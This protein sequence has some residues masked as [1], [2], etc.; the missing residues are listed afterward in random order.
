MFGLSILEAARD[1][2]TMDS[3]FFIVEFFDTLIIV[4]AIFFTATVAIEARE[5]RKSTHGLRDE[6]TRTKAKS[7]EWQ[8]AAETY[9]EGIG[10]AICEQF[11]AWGLS[12][13]ESEVAMLILKGLS[14]K[15]IADVRGIGEATVRQQAQAVY[16]KSG[17]RGRNELSAYFLE[18]ITL[19]LGDISTFKR[20]GVS[21]MR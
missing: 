2:D 6:L 7:A 14:H 16:S 4:A 10:K 18:D 5:L 1:G 21:Y 8:H 17:L 12:K 13:G 11:G 20:N 9:S 3:I 15:E 19:P